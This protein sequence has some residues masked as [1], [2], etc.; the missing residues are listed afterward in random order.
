MIIKHFVQAAVLTLV[1]GFS[2]SVH[3]QIAVVVS[4]STANAMSKEQISDVFMGV[5][6]ELSP[7]D[8]ADGS[9]VREDFYQKLTGK[10]PAQVKAY[11]SKL[12]FTGKAKPPRDVSDNSGVK[13]AV[14]SGNTIGYIDQAAVDSSVK[15][16]ITLN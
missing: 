14:S 5:S 2:V 12:I 16:L 6:S 4:S 7:V 1:Y 8:Q 3:A 15:V 11:W 9:K 13:K 10:S